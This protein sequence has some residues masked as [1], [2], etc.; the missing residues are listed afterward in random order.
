MLTGHPCHHVYIDPE[1]ERETM[2]VL[3]T[4]RLHLSYFYNI[5][6]V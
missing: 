1:V 4:V 2:T 6:V 3:G 5:H